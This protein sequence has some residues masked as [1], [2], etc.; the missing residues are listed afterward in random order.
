MRMRLPLITADST[1][2]GMRATSQ[3]LVL[4]IQAYTEESMTVQFSDPLAWQVHYAW[5]KPEALETLVVVDNSDFLAQT[6]I[7][8]RQEEEQTEGVC[9]FQ[10]LTIFREV[11]CEVIAHSVRINGSDYHVANETVES[12]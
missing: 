5:Y 9:S 4:D 1:I 11:L 3:G 6:L 2:L 12:L 7:T 8:L 10:F